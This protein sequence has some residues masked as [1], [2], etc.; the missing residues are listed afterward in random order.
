MNICVNLI[1][2]ERKSLWIWH[3][4]THVRSTAVC[5]VE[6]SNLWRWLFAC[7]WVTTIALLGLKVKVW[8]QGRTLKLK[9]RGQSVVIGT[10][11]LN[12][13]Q[14][15]SSVIYWLPLV[16]IVVN[17]VANVSCIGL[18][19]RRI[20]QQLRAPQCTQRCRY[21]SQMICYSHCHR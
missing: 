7:V 9:V 16:G 8:G 3:I 17:C 5:L 13:G 12:R 18:K 6:L 19:Q 1:Q 10:M 21:A 4:Y 2:D 20:L 15:S 11:I 14:F